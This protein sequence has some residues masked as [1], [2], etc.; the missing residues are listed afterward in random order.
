MIMGFHHKTAEFDDN[1][2]IESFEESAAP[3]AKSVKAILSS[4]SMGMWDSDLIMITELPVRVKKRS[5]VE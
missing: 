2:P 3:E 4:G 1:Y 5:F